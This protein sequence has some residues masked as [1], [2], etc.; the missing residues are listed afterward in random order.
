MAQ[1][2]EDPGLVL[3]LDLS[4]LVVSVG[5][6]EIGVALPA[7]ARDAFLT[8][9][10]DATGLLLDRFDEVRRVAGRLP[11]VAGWSR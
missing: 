10:W 5:D 11:Y 3:Q 7:P 8:G 9:S 1:V 2:E 4:R 6:R